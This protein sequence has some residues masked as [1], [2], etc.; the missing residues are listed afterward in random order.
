MPDDAGRTPR[1]CPFDDAQVGESIIERLV[2]QGAD[3][4]STD[5]ESRTPLTR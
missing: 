4:S 1:H 3:T 2:E 5:K